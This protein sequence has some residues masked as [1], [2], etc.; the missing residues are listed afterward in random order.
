M[1]EN[2]R[3]SLKGIVSH[4]MRSVLTMLGVIIGITSIIVIVAI[5]QGATESLK[6][7]MIGNDTN[8]VTIGLFG[9]S[10][11]YFPYEA[12][13]EGS[14]QGIGKISKT[15]LKAIAEIKDVS[16]VTPIYH[17]IS[18]TVY[19]A[20]ESRGD[21]YGVE[22]EYFA[23]SDIYLVTGRLFS[24]SDY[25]KKNN[26]VVLSAETAGQLFD[27]EDPIGKTIQVENELFVVIGIVDKNKDYSDINTLTDYY[28]KVGMNSNEVYI[29]STSWET[30][31]GF[32]DIQSAVIKI[33]NLDEIVNISEAAADILNAEINGVDYEYKSTSIGEDSQQL[34]QVTGIA[35]LLLVGIASISLLVGGIG[36]MNIML[37]S[38]TERTREIGLKKALGAKRR[39]ILSQFLTEAVVLTGMGGVI[40]VVLGIAIAKA[41]GLIMGMTIMVN[42]PVV[43]LAVGFSMFVGI[44][45]GW[46]P[47]I[48]ASKLDPI[49]ALRY[50]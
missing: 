45:F 29:P 38:V 19:K 28:L 3:I 50:E 8:T 26:V 14:V 35:Y 20:E 23:A 37:V 9:P 1:F 33:D 32:D 21:I 48:K 27:N 43:C 11:P 47:S 39:A 13:F 6:T 12:Q 25:E 24:E 46:I 4:K 36:V 41:L 5:I 34:E 7:M 22:K 31:C 42:I 40:G 17:R 18:K 16:V 15:A 2:I 44:V 30:A 10:D 49:E